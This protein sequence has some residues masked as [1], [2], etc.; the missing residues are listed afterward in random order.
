MSGLVVLL[1]LM[2]AASHAAWNAA[3]KSGPDPLWSVTVMQ[4]AEL[5][6]GLLLLAF[7]PMPAAEA[8]PWLLAGA[9]THTLYRIQLARTYGMGGL[10]EL[11]PILR[12]VAPLLVTLGAAA[13]ASEWPPPL[14]LAG[15][16]VVSLGLM[17]QSR[18][19]AVGI[20][21][22]AILAAVLTG[23]LISAYT[24][25]DGQGARL[26]GH[27]IGFAVWLLFVSGATQVIAYV[28]LRGFA[29]RGPRR[30]VLKSVG[31]GVLSM[32]TYATVIWALSQ[33]P[34]G[35]IS[36]LRETSVVF[37]AVIGRVFLG[38]SVT[39]RRFAAC[40]VVALGAVLIGFGARG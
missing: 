9:V 5:S 24:V 25:I 19:G 29:F 32:A 20:P 2:A 40:I 15:I 35:A 27:A 11:Y 6:I 14:A 17:A 26:S 8:W 18:A 10:A 4:A 21:P 22:R 28:G 23:V 7:V 1:V 34:M 36:A 31:L 3:L 13:V 33:G 38:E 37:A 39:P 12:G 30:E 16:V